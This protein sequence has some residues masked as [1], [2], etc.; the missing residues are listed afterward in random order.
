MPNRRVMPRVRRAFTLIEV[1][2]ATSILGIVGVTVSSV[3]MVA[4]RSSPPATGGS[5]TDVAV[6]QALAVMAIDIG[7][8]SKFLATETG[9]VTFAGADANGDGAADEIAYAF[10]DESGGQLLRMVG[11]DLSTMHTGLSDLTF[12]YLTGTVTVGDTTE[13]VVRAVAIRLEAADGSL[14]RRT[15]RCVGQP[16]MP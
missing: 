13:S 3:L 4:A 1:I 16:T 9:Y 5:A 8:A 11:A 14:Y 6:S 2:L 10:L 12:S 7:L 15:I